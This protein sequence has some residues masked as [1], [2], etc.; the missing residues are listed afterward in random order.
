MDLNDPSGISI[1]FFSFLSFLLS[2]S[3]HQRAVLTP[4]SIL[5][6]TV[7]YCNLSKKESLKWPCTC[8]LTVRGLKSDISIKPV[9]Y[10]QWD[11]THSA[12]LNAKKFDTWALV[13]W[14]T[15]FTVLQAHLLLNLLFKRDMFLWQNAESNHF[16]T[17]SKLFV[18]NTF[19]VSALWSSLLSRTLHKL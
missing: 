2:F 19:F 1:S 14:L 15:P 4:R 17:I 6:V 16:K 10:L 18:F 13:S 3:A 11:W 9:T 12:N 7:H 5:P 8:G